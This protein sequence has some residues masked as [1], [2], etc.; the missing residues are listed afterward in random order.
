MTIANKGV[1]YSPTVLRSVG[2]RDGSRHSGETVETIPDGVV[3]DII[4]EGMVSST[5]Y[6]Y[7]NFA[8]SQLDKPTAIKTGS[9]QSPRGYDSTV[10]GFYPADKPE[11]AFAVVLEGGANAKHSAYPL[12]KAYKQTKAR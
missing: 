7:G 11:I 6:T 9:P 10:I 8:L 12:I 3:F 4:T 2:Y 5:K 1:R